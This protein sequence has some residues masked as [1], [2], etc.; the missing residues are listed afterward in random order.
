MSTDINGRFKARNGVRVFMCLWWRGAHGMR[1]FATRPLVCLFGLHTN[2]KVRLGQARLPSPRPL[3]SGLQGL[4]LSVP[5]QLMQLD[6]LHD[7]F[8]RSTQTP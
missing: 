6:T 2:G 8:R 3:R 7:P 4:T 1:R 5:F